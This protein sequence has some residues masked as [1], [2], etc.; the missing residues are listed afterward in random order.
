MTTGQV[1]AS[2]HANSNRGYH[3]NPTIST[4]Y[5]SNNAVYLN[6]NAGYP[7]KNT[8]GVTRAFVENSANPGMSPTPSISV[9]Y[10][11]KNDNIANNPNV[12]TTYVESGHTNPGIKKTIQ[13]Y[14][15]T[16]QISVDEDQYSNPGNY[17]DAPL[18]P[19]MGDVIYT[20]PGK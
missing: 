17:G 12:A 3:S 13:D 10:L 16:L 7:S 20:Q 18:R 9:T 11:N 4:T 15:G 8:G 5:P 6:N 2:Y 14:S 1:H 19:S